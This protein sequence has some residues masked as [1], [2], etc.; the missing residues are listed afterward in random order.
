PLS[1]PDA[2]PSFAVARGPVR[3]QRDF[4]LEL[5]LAFDHGA[6]ADHDLRLALADLHREP[7]RRRAVDGDAAAHVRV[8]ADGDVAADGGD[9]AAKVDVDQADGAV[10]RGHVAAHAAA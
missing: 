3:V 6:R 2:L 7:V 1:L 9:A 8:D 5:Q 10:D 4:A